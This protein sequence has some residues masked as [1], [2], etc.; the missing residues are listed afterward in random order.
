MLVLAVTLSFI[1]HFCIGR[2]ENFEV[3]PII[4]S[5]KVQKCNQ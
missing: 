2:A 5:V 4:V 1:C 3:G